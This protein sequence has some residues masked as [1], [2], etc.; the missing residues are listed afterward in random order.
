MIIVVLYLLI[1]WLHLFHFSTPLHAITNPLSVPNN[2]FGIHI[3]DENDLEDASKLVN[4][5]GGDWGYVKMVIRE[6]DRE[7]T[8]WQQ[9][10]DRMRRL[11]VIPIVRIA[12]S[13]ENGGW[14]KPNKDNIPS[15]VE[16]LDSLNWVTENRYVIL[17][18]EPNHAK[19][20]GG[21]L[22]PEEYAETAKAFSLALKARSPDFFVLPAGLD[23][24]A[25]N[26]QE[27]M[28]EITFI[29][30]MVATIPEF[31]TYF[32]GWSSH[33]YPNPHFSGS[34]Y[35][36]GRGTINT[37]LWELTQFSLYG[38]A[39]LPVFITE[40]GWRHNSGITPN[41]AILS[42]EI[43]AQRFQT[44][45]NGSWQDRRIVAIIP[46]LLNY[47]ERPFDEFSWRKL[48]SNEF[49]PVYSVVQAIEKT[50]GMP[51]QRTQANLHRTS[52]PNKL[53]TNS[54]YRF[55]V[56]FENSGQ[57]I[58]TQ[59]EWAMTIS[60][61]PSTFT[62]S[63]SPITPLEP[64]GL[65]RIEIDLETPDTPG[66]YTYTLELLFRSQHIDQSKAQFTLIPPPSLLVSSRTWFKHKSQ[67]NDF[68]LKVYDS[69]GRLVHDVRGASFNVGISQI[70]NLYN[71][72]PGKTYL[73]KLSQPYHIPRTIRVPLNENITQVTFPTLLPFDFSGDQRFDSS[74]IIEFFLHPIASLK[75]MFNLE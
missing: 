31:Y 58:I 71:V 73:L 37:F 53:V 26:S 33:S 38:L 57:S 17:F 25:P 3:I 74:D 64:G 54:R 65:E 66:S 35:G 20:W 42:P 13:V 72:I 2:K 46:F 51:V 27:T 16:F 4:S 50:K 67:G 32:D 47:Q 18:N 9:I 12:T 10:F 30:R 68:N 22:S 70:D 6:N 49:Y 59:E 15:W 61:L 28:D 29:R 34:S 48:N 52:I 43:V 40:T 63:I 23:A 41:G 7:T 69:E 5:Q 75:L 60:D 11:R 21:T 44:A 55:T 19:E 62:Y 45:F 39:R 8:K 24:S 1:V 36:V 14:I 56:D